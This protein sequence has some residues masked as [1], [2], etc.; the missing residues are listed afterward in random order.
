MLS[1][2]N[3]QVAEK[4]EESSC[5]P[6]AN[7]VQGEVYRGIIHRE[8]VMSWEYEVGWRWVGGG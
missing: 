4:K 2:W 7:G 3:N 6:G 1:R 5:L 8:F